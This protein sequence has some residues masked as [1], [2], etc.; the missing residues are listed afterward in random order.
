[1]CHGFVI[2]LV[3]CL[4]THKTTGHYRQVIKHI[5]DEVRRATHRSLRP[6]HMV[7]DFEQGLMTAVETEMPTCR[8][9]G[10]YFHFVQS[11]W[12]RI[13]EVGLTTLYRHHERLRQFIRRVMAIGFLPVL[14]VRQNFVMLRRCRRTRRLIRRFPALDDWLQYV[15]TAYINSNTLPPL[16]WNVY[17]RDMSSRTNN[18]V[19]GTYTCNDRFQV[20]S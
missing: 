12:R 18:N 6:S 4:T 3:F 8:L 13:Q 10:C 5:K 7:L 19:E 1:M 11:L 9:A 20:L 16:V 14:L 17:E 2:P 15:E